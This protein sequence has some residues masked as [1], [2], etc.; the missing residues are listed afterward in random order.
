[1]S[2]QTSSET[3]ILQ[4]CS[5]SKNANPLFTAGTISSGVIDLNSNTVERLNTAL[6]T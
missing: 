6:Y 1:M 5:F 3:L 4:F 2:A